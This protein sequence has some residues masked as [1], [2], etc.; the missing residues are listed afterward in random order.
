MKRSIHQE[1]WLVQ[2]KKE[3][4]R[5]NERAH[6]S[7]DQ[8]RYSSNQSGPSE[9]HCSNLGQKEGKNQPKPIGAAPRVYALTQ[10]DRGA[11]TFDMVSSQL[12]VATNSAHA[13]KDTGASHS[14]IVASYVDRKDRKLEPMENVC[15][16]SLL[17]GKDMMVR[18]WARVVPVWVESRELTVDLLVL[19]LDEYDVIFGMDWLTKCGAV[20][21]CKQR[22]VAFN[23]H[24]EELFVFPDTTQEKNF[25]IISTSK[26]RKLRDDGCIGYLANVIDKDRVSKTQPTKVVVV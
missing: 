7:N 14:F 3:P 16:V 8:G 18:S 12:L 25:S 13:V 21:N 5:A 10:G 19:D 26:F 23:P 15:V 20:V 22:K 11:G 24:G 9:R 4:Y 2:E 1:S 17:S 6:V